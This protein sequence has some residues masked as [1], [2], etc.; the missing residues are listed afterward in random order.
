MKTAHVM[1]TELADSPDADVGQLLGRHR[2]HQTGGGGGGGGGM[3]LVGTAGLG[4]DYRRPTD[5]DA[6]TDDPFEG[7]FSSAV[8]R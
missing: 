7:G 8:R 5:V 6:A 4:I 3:W 2:P 1:I